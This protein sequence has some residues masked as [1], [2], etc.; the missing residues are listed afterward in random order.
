MKQSNMYNHGIEDWWRHL[1]IWDRQQ[2]SGY[3]YE[4]YDG[5]TQIYLEAT[6]EWWESLSGAQKR[7]V[8]MEFFSEE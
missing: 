1:G 2:A 7:D 5:E 4:N 6:D 8:F 3:L